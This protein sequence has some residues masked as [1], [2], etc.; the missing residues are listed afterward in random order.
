MERLRKLA[1]DPFAGPLGLIAIVGFAWRVFYTLALEPRFKPMVFADEAWYVAQAHR[2]FG[3]HPFSQVANQ[4][5]LRIDPTLPSAQHG[6]LASLL[7]APLAQLTHSVTVLRLQNVALGTLVIVVVGLLGRQVAGAR[8]GL[9][10]AGLA[11]LDPGLWIRDGI[12]ASEP[13]AELLVATTLLLAFRYLSAASWWRAA[14]LGLVLGLAVLARPELMLFA[15]LVGAPVLL[16]G[17]WRGSSSDTQPWARRLG[18]PV[19]AAAVALATLSPWLAYNHGRFDSSV[20]LT[21]NLG[22]TLVGANCDAGFYG[23]LAGYDDFFCWAASYKRAVKQTTDEAK[24]SQLMR[25]DAMGYLH[26]HW[27]RLVVVMPMRE[28]WLLGLRSPSW[29]VEQSTYIGQPRWATWSQAVS[30][31]FILALTAVGAI[32]AKRRRITT[33]PLWMSVASMLLVAA[34][35]VGHWRYRV[36]A[37]VALLVLAAIGLNALTVAWRQRDPQASRDSSSS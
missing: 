24:Q 1:R 27:G 2:L 15:V 14:G 37:E 25:A 19:L 22:T 33:W 3:A 29:V 31:W 34:A 23:R 17:S 12:A 4:N 28:A 16:L 26:Q 7:L 10:A 9:I 13:L 5:Y 18:A 11:A 30:F 6:P 36:S 20:T 8:V 32:A 35:F 21:D